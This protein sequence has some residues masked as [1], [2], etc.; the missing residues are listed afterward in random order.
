MKP[1]KDHL[2]VLVIDDDDF[3]LNAIKKKLELSGYKVTVSNNVHD[4]YFKLSITKP[5]IIL[6]DIIMPDINGIEFM[7]LINSQMT[8]DKVPIM[9]MSYLPKK[10]IFDMGYNIS[11]AHYLPKPFNV[12]RLPHILNGILLHA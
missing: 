7:S 2:H 5:D 1:K 10:E 11:T 4:A 3:L 9:L 12:N 8:S 6:L